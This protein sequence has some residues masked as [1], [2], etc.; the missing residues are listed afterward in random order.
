MNLEKATLNSLDG[1]SY[2]FTFMYNPTSISINH[3]VNV[4]ENDGARTEDKG[5]PKVSFAHPKATTI[6]IQDIIFDTYENSSDRDVGNQ[7]KKLTQSVKFIQGKQRPPVYIFAWGSINY[8][9][10]YVESVSY[11][12]T[13]FL[14]NGTPVRARASISMKEV[15]PYQGM[16]NPPPQSNRSVDS[17][18]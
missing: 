17:R 7:L 10:C 8:L 13:M 15:D 9:R 11:Q 18:W 4:S 12:L 3:S 2:S 14:P 16:S 5:I 1:G 6:F